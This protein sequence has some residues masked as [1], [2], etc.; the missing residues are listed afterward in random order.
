[1][2][3][4]YL[5]VLVVDDSPDDAELPV[6]VLK[7]AGY[8]VKSQRIYSVTG[9]E[10]ALAG[11]TWDLVLSELSLLQFSAQMALD[12][13]KREQLDLPLIVFTRTI[14]DT[15]FNK[16]IRLGARD[17]VRKSFNVRLL[18]A[19]ER[20]LRALADRRELEQARARLAEISG[21]REAMVTGTQEAVCYTHEGMHIEANQSYLSLFGYAN[22]DELQT[23]PVLDLIDRNDHKLFKDALKKAGRPGTGDKALELHAIRKDGGTLQISARFSPV[24]L[25]GEDCIQITVE[26]ISQRKATEDRLNYLT[27]H[28]PLTGL[29]NRHYF[30]K[31]L[32][33][34][35]KTARESRK[36]AALL[37]FD[38][39][40]LKEIS[41]KYGYTTGD[42]ILLKLAK[43]FREQLP[44]DAMVARF[45]DEELT[46]VVTGCDEASAQ[47]HLNRLK[48]AIASASFSAGK[49]KVKCGC[50]TSCVL[51]DDRLRNAHDAVTDAIA[52]AE[53]EKPQPKV[54]AAAVPVAPAAA[55][56]APIPAAPAV[57]APSIV[58][59]ALANN[60]FRLVY[61][62]IV[63]MQGEADEMFEVLI[64]LVDASNQ[65]LVPA[66]FMPQA[67]RE[68]LISAI[69]RWV[70][71][72]VLE[73]LAAMKHDG[74]AITYFV[75]LSV[76]D[77][78]DRELM[79]VLTKGLKQSDI[80]ADQLVLELSH[81]GVTENIEKTSN[82]IKAV[83]KLGCRISL[84][85][86]GP[87]TDTL[88]KLPRKSIRFLKFDGGV[89]TRLVQSGD[90]EALG[91]I[92]DMAR[93]LNIKTV[94]THIEDAGRLADIWPHGFDYVQ[95]H[96][97]QQPD[98]ELNYEFV[99]DG[100]TTLGG[101]EITA[102]S[103]TQ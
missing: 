26:D 82:F 76:I 78:D 24:K 25:N 90:A 67:A 53:A 28:D 50:A 64:R 10:S 11:E 8:R 14:T 68:G 35:W 69:D 59:E 46:A 27:Q 22:L 17:V 49:D 29:Y 38:L 7:D 15:E 58:A 16:I 81:T 91:A 18:P 96:Y 72:R 33:S 6:R 97:F 65:L 54:A 63:S 66:Q 92:M 100:E 61:Q 52:R 32:G 43:L 19:I 101:D 9:M 47:D 48:S 4:K 21:Q 94:A 87:V 95:G 5:R 60:R 62:P 70:L 3:S 39:Y 12:V 85:N 71:Q 37:Y 51:I 80:D 79:D 93:Q 44:E 36:P 34:V 13:L 2:E 74:R 98:S 30:T 99:A 20:E 57:P 73:S 77:L 88:F 56:T 55:A 102:P 42:A 40:Q 84:E 83:Q 23:V 41:S 86:A 31:T 89:V 103:W 75:N 1:M 45:G